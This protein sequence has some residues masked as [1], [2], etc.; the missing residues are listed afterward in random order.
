MESVSCSRKVIC[1][2]VKDDS[3]ES[4][5]TALTWFS[6]RTGNTT[7]FLGSTRISAE[8]TG[9]AS[10]GM[11][12]TSRCRLSSAHWPISPSPNCTNCGCGLLP[13]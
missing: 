7:T 8:L 11:S 2:L 1:E 10:L 4:S 12:D 13:S 3:E 5:M 9:T 6:N